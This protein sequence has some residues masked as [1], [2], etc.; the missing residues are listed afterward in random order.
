MAAQTVKIKFHLPHFSHS[1][2][3]DI[4]QK[5]PPTSS[6][7]ITFLYWNWTDNSWVN[8]YHLK[9]TTLG[10]LLDQGMKTPCLDCIVWVRWLTIN[11]FH[12]L[13]IYLSGFCR[14]QWCVALIFWVDGRPQFSQRTLDLKYGSS[15]HGDGEKRCNF[16][17]TWTSVQNQKQSNLSQMGK[18]N[19]VY[20]LVNRNGFYRLWFVNESV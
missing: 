13:C 17:L 11:M 7:D 4:S 1:S 10:E 16:Q 5:F 14:W 9:D 3:S 15:E 6:A 8:C 20:I 19:T 12:M 2:Y 18:I